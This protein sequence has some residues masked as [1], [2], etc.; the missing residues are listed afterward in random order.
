MQDVEVIDQPTWP[1]HNAPTAPARLSFRAEWEATNEVVTYNNNA[2]LFHFKGWR[3]VGRLEASVDVRGTGF[4]W[5][6]DPIA[7]SRSAFGVIGE[8]TNGRYF[9]G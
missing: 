3:A 9:N 6:S 1:D 2:K 7:S 4:S 8:E 5:R